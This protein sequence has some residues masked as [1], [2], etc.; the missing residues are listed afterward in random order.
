MNRAENMLRYW[1]NPGSDIIFQ[2]EDSESSQP[3]FED[4]GKFSE[5]TRNTFLHNGGLTSKIYTYF[6][7]SKLR[8]AG[9]IGINPQRLKYNIPRQFYSLDT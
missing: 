1:R 2:K 8:N 5:L 6:D 9:L 4:N 3:V 7:K